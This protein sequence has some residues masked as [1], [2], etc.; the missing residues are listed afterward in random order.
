M[1]LVS[2]L[3]RAIP[4]VDG[5]QRITLHDQLLNGLATD[6]TC[7]N[8]LTASTTMMTTMTTMTSD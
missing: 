5:H 7:G 2:P 8:C 6:R 4:E 3:R 1:V